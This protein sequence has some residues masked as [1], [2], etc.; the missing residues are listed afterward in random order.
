MPWTLDKLLTQAAQLDQPLRPVVSNVA[1]KADRDS[2]TVSGRAYNV[3]FYS[4]GGIG[5]EGSATMGKNQGAAIDLP[6]DGSVTASANA[7]LLPWFK[8]KLCVSNLAQK[9]RFFFTSKLNS[10]GIFIAGG[11]CNPTVVHANAYAAIDIPDDVGEAGKRQLI[12]QFQTIYEGMAQGLVARGELDP[13]N[14]VI[15]RPGVLG[16]EGD[17]AVFGVRPSSNWAFYAV[18]GSAKNPPVHKIWPT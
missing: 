8:D 15:F 17:A 16:Y 10:C 1:E 5:A 9:H 18:I 13:D 6:C 4:K 14:L 7:Y 11:L 2:L 12:G 3:Y